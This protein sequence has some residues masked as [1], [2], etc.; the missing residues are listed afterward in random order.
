MIFGDYAPRG[1]LPWQLPKSRAQ[2]ATFTP[3]ELAASDYNT[4]PHS[5]WWARP[6]E[7]RIIPYDLGATAAERQVIRSAIL[8]GKEPPNNLGDPLFNYGFGIQGW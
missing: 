5:Q 2:V 3:A 6:V 7:D 4:N 1:R 8:A